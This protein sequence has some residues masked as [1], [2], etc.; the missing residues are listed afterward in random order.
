M[1]IRLSNKLPASGNKMFSSGKL[2][3]T[4]KGPATRGQRVE[5]QSA[6]RWENKFGNAKN[7]LHLEEA[8]ALGISNVAPSK[9]V[10]AA[11]TLSTTY[12]HFRAKK[13]ID[14]VRAD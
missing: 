1:E 4:F 10:P 2:L 13:C 11:A 8:F 3:G 14:G 7:F 5:I 9:M 6:N 12:K